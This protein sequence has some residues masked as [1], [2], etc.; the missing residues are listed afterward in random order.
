MQIQQGEL[1]ASRNILTEAVGLAKDLG[2]RL[3]FN[4]LAT[5]YHDLRKHWP[6]E[7]SVAVLEELFQPW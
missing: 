6:N 1:E 4:K 5:S 7:H 3:Y 2:S